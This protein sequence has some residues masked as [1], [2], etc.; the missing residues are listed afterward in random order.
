MEGPAVTG[1]ASPSYRLRA[2]PPERQ[3]VLDRLTSASRRFQVHALLELDVTEASSRIRNSDEQVSWTGFVIA[4]LA[5]A[6]V[7]HPEVNARKAGKHILSFDRVDIGATVERQWEG[8]TVL[9]IL[10]ITDAD[11]LSC[12]EISEL[13]H[14]T[15]YGPGQPHTTS[16]LTRALLR[17]PGPLRRTGIRIAALRPNVAGSF[18]PTVGVTSLGMFSSGWG[19]AIPVAPLTVTATVGG[20]TLRP[21]AHEGRVEVRPLLPLTLSFDHA[22]IDG[23]PATRFTETMRVLVETAAALQPYQ[24]QQ[25]GQGQQRGGAPTDQEHGPCRSGEDRDESPGRST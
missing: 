11:R 15:K 8:R 17:L 10:T 2:V 14:R 12:H 24:G 21:A 1:P 25:P 13:L 9:D 18:G 20:V 22:V 19:W 23:A 5:R 3:P 4:S 6:M 7:Q 16:R